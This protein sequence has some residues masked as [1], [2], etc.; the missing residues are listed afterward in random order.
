MRKW[1]EPYA[2]LDY[3]KIGEGRKEKAWSFWLFTKFLM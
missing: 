1:R 3:T 2:K